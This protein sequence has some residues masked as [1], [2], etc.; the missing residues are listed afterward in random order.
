MV[1]TVKE[2]KTMHINYYKVRK[3]LMAGMEI[4]G[5]AGDSCQVFPLWIYGI[6][7]AVYIPLELSSFLDC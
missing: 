2:N 4:N 1:K 3:E 6:V 7:P 5:E